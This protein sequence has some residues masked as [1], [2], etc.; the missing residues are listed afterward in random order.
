MRACGKLRCQQSLPAAEPRTSR[1]GAS[2]A[3]EQDEC[4]PLCAAPVPSLL[5]ECVIAAPAYR[6]DLRCRLAR[7]SEFVEAPGRQDSL[8]RFTLR[9][10]WRVAHAS[11]FATVVRLSFQLHIQ[12]R[13]TSRR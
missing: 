7:L 13:A 10:F 8:Q 12:G 5:L 2:A 6:T 11:F 9:S 4:V 3:E 1:A